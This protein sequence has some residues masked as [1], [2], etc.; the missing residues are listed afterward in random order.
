MEEM[1]KLT[2]KDILNNI[3]NKV[4]FATIPYIMKYFKTVQV[5]NVLQKLINS[6][7]PNS[8]NESFEIIKEVFMRGLVI[9]QDSKSALVI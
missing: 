7:D 5:Y 8:I 4:I 3:A 6:I 2:D 9:L 1:K